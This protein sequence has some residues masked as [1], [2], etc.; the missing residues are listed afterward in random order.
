MLNHF[1]F[2]SFR[3]PSCGVVPM[4]CQ[5]ATC[6]SLWCGFC[7]FKKNCLLGQLFFTG[8]LL[9]PE[10]SFILWIPVF[11]QVYALQ[12]FSISRWLVSSLS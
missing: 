8:L 3:G 7:P 12:V 9:S 10:D 1:S 5:I 4:A 2:L 11:H 6:I